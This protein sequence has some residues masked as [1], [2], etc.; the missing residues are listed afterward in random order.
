LFV[1]S[2]LVGRSIDDFD[3]AIRIELRLLKVTLLMAGSNYLTTGFLSE[4]E[5]AE[6]SKFTD[7]SRC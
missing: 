4:G 1:G 3:L 6:A 2:S 5:I 7:A